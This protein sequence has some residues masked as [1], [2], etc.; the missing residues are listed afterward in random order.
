MA[1]WIAAASTT[2]RMRYSLCRAEG[3]SS[4]LAT[5]FQICLNTI[6]LSEPATRPLTRPIGR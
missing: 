6:P 2:S 1:P 4:S 3:A 5:T